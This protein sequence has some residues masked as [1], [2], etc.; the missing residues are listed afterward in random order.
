MTTETPS[1][2]LAAQ[3]QAEM[4]ALAAQEAEVAT[5]KQIIKP[6]IV[7][8]TRPDG[9]K[10]SNNPGVPASAAV[11]KPRRGR[12]KELPKTPHERTTVYRYEVREKQPDFKH[13]K[14][15]GKERVRLIES[16]EPIKSVGSRSLP[17]KV[18]PLDAFNRS[19]GCEL[20]AADLDFTLI[21][22][23]TK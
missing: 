8:T 12:R 11:A 6:G 5:V 22:K 23:S 17:G 21:Y 16:S 14:A 2:D 7:T 9:I 1:I 18:S 19:F 10:V 20:K 3:A 4:T 15:T 13:Y